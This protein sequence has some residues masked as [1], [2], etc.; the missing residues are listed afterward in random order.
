MDGGWGAAPLNRLFLQR[1]V[2]M[3]YW[4]PWQ[5]ARDERGRWPT[6]TLLSTTY[7]SGSGDDVANGIA[8]GPDG[9]IWIVGNTTSTNLPTQS[10]LYSSLSG[11]QDAFVAKFDPTGSDL[12][13][14]SYFGAGRTT[15]AWPSR[16]IPRG[17]GIFGLRRPRAPIPRAAAHSRPAIPTPPTVPASSPSSPA[18]A[19]PSPGAPTSA[20]T[21]PRSLVAALAVDV[22]GNVYAGGGRPTNPRSAIPSPSPPHPAPCRPVPPALPMVSWK[23][24]TARALPC[25]MAPSTA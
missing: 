16:S 21:A 10:P 8:I 12:L 9:S 2:R 17:T 15:R 7:F 1:F 13:F 24:S 20:A 23:N 25:P 5:A 3:A 19:R 18:P 11:T 6:G 14:S 4:P 22:S